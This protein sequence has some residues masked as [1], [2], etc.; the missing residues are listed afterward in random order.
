ML[1][2]EN[3]LVRMK[4][5]E[6]LHKEGVFVPGKMVNLNVWKIDPT[7]YPRRKYSVGDLKIGFAVGLKISKSAVKRNRI[8]RQLREVV[9]LLL[10][11]GKIK[12]GFM[13]V[14]LPKPNILDKEYREIEEEIVMV[15]K[16][17]DLFC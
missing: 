5:F 11:D 9:R 4:D 7:K 15:L 14:F 8:K 16:R 12:S 2:K 10:K 13:M 1:S 3:R 17:A 6:I